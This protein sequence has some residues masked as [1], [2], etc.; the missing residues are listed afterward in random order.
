MPPYYYERIAKCAL[1]VG[2]YVLADKRREYD[3]HEISWKYYKLYLK[4]ANYWKVPYHDK[5]AQT[6]VANLIE[7]FETMLTPLIKEQKR[8]NVWKKDIDSLKL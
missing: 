8:K 4:Y 1:Q 5:T 3:Y 7:Q 6:M 2:N